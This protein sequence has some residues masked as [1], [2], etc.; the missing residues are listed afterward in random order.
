MNG[1]F[2]R[3]SPT[4]LR[5][6]RGLGIEFT[7]KT[8]FGLVSLFSLLGLFSLCGIVPSHNFCLV[9]KTN[10]S[11]FLPL[12][13]SLFTTNKLILSKLGTW[14]GLHSSRLV[15]LG[16]GVSLIHAVFF[17]PPTAPCS[18]TF[19]T[20]SA[21]RH[22]SGIYISLLNRAAL[23]QTLNSAQP[24]G[25]PSSAWLPIGSPLFMWLKKGAGLTA[26]TP[27]ELYRL[28]SHSCWLVGGQI[29]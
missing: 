15:L 17:P 14:V 11:I 2:T 18:P 4:A 24:Q 19:S 6:K 20:R 8:P 5:A 28:T 25:L 26:G 10:F 23:T 7:N 29:T 27:L 13:L 16:L 1:C 21:H 12:F 9:Y 3:W 22:S